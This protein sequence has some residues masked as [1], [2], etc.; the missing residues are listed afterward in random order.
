MVGRRLGR[1][2]SMLLRHENEWLA[3]EIE[4]S[5]LAGNDGGADRDSMI[6]EGGELQ[7]AINQY[8][9]FYPLF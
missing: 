5:S 9:L 6:N 3:A 1:A 7:E 8:L 4:R 2:H